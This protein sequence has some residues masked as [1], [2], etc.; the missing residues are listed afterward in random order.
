MEAAKREVTPAPATDLLGGL[1]AR[2]QVTEA[3]VT[4]PP[5]GTESAELKLLRALVDQRIGN[6]PA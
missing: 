6:L 1:P 5:V 2:A 4:A 3:A